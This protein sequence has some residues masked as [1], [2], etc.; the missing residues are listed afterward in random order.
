MSRQL[1]ALLPVLKWIAR[2]KSKK[3]KAFLSSCYNKV[4]NCFS[5]CVRNI[6]KGNVELKKG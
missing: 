5:E 3:Q 1:R 2:M 6:L 4:I